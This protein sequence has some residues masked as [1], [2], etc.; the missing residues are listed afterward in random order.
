[1]GGMRSDGLETAEERSGGG[2]VGGESVGALRFGGLPTD[3]PASML[4]FI[5]LHLLAK[6][7]FTTTHCIPVKK[8]DTS[9]LN[10]TFALYNW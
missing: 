7:C 10:V 5:V 8:G 1:M 4:P 3:F 9:H 6:P 2:V